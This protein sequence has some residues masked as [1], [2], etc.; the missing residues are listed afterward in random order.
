MVTAIG[1]GS[2]FEAKDDSRT[3]A[4]TGGS[5]TG[6]SS[7][8]GSGGS[9][10]GGSSTG[11]TSGAGP[12]GCPS[13]HRCVPPAPPGWS[14]PYAL[15]EDAACPGGW[16]QEALVVHDGLNAGD[17][18]CECTCQA[19][20]TCPS[21]LGWLS[22]NQ[23]GCP[24][25]ATGI[26]TQIGVGDCQAANAL[27]THGVQLGQA[28]GACEPTVTP[29]VPPATWGVSDRLCG[30]ATSAGQCEKPQ[31]SCLP[32]AGVSLCVE[33]P[34]ELEC[35]GE[36]PT[37]HVYY[38]GIDDTRK[39]P[40]TCPCTKTGNFACKAYFQ[41][42]TSMDCTTGGT[43]ESVS[44]GSWLCLGGSLSAKLDSF[45]VTSVGTCT[46]GTAIGSGTATPKDA[47]TV[48]CVQ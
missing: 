25:D 36:Y 14:G 28:T 41:S 20:T 23:A 13:N 10:T 33:Q 5:S 16:G 31:D 2:D 4:A 47:H 43:S 17:P 9:S 29:N 24:L 15:T 37:K 42:Y 44:T 27:P 22:I 6:G 46:P 3:D 45:S 18:E 34:G 8:G 32:S 39:C 26:P 19:K 38:T 48:C 30:G 1:C 21:T 40:N 7:T 12:G 11:G 35:P